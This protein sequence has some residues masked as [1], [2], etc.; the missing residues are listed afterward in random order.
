[1]FY[2]Q[3]LF[4]QHY[5]QT[6]DISYNLIQNISH[7]PKRENINLCKDYVKT[8][9]FSKLVVFKTREFSKLYNISKIVSKPEL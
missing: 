9:G 3:T 6:G 8:E 4:T 1:M 5:P 2:H 7:F